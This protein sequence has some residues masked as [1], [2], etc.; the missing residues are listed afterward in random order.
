MKTIYLV[1][2][3]NRYSGAPKLIRAYESRTDAEDMVEILKVIE[4]E[5]IEIAELKYQPT[6]TYSHDPAPPRFLG[7]SQPSL[8][9]LP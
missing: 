2:K 3:L 5:G 4:I 9:E 7:V 8:A 6:Q 1:Q